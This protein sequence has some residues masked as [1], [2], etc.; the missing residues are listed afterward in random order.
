MKYYFLLFF[1]A[2]NA[3]AAEWTELKIPGAK[4]GDGRP[5][6]VLLQKKDNQKL[7]IEF[8][9]GGVC[10]DYHS[11][12]E[13]NS[14][15]PWLH[16]YPV[17][18]S[19]SVFTANKS[20]IN[21]F[22]EHSKIYFPYCTADV[23]SGNHISQYN[24]KQVY[25]YGKRNVELAFEFIKSSHLFEFSNVNDLV[26]S[27]SSAGAI[28][29]LLHSKYIESFVP[30]QTKKTMIVD[31]PG[32]HFGKT[33]WNKFD[34]DMKYDFK[35]S[36]NKI[37]L[38]VDFNDGAIS[39]KM[40]PVL[41]L[42]HNWEIGFIFALEDHAMSTVYGDISPLD[43]KKLLLSTDGVPYIARD[44]PYVKVWLKDTTMHT[45]LLTKYSASLTSDEGEKVYQFVSDV[46]QDK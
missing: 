38:D 30:E 12:F 4:C 10:W 14:L 26:V 19:Y 6:S 34:N 29:T 13:R 27:G 25:H 28:A 11:C 8:M 7:L 15:F 21:P 9:G 2:I 23:H 42:Y 35:Q 1:I 33:F 18:N 5:Y 3:M 32:L 36:F 43:H 24:D 41:Q 44:Y 39:K 17:I 37:N 46:Y 45:F 31:S 22:K 20:Q 40:G 16:P